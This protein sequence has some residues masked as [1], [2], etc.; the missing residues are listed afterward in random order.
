MSFKYILNM[1][2]SYNFKYICNTIYNETKLK[3]KIYV[4]NEVYDLIIIKRNN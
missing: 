4:T 1:L 3:S 2:Y